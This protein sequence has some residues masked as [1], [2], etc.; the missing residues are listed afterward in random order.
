MLSIA[1]E[2]D[3]KDVE[4]EELVMTKTEELVSLFSKLIEFQSV[5]FEIKK[6]IGEYFLSNISNHVKVFLKTKEL[7]LNVKD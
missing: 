1:L 6:Q 2:L 4:E 5:F 7:F 3:D